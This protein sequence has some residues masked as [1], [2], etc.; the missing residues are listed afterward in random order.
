MWGTSSSLHYR[1]G[2]NRRQMMPRPAR[3]APLV[4]WAY[5]EPLSPP[6]QTLDGQWWSQPHFTGENIEPHVK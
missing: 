6:R 3:C 4:F 5:S 2:L 1:T